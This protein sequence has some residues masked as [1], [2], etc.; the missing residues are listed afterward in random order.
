MSISR[1]KLPNASND[2]SNADGEA[3]MAGDVQS[4]ALVVL[5]LGRDWGA[6]PTRRRQDVGV[7]SETREEDGNEINV[8]H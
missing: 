7:A 5:C 8:Q 2:K 3:E 1:R 4:W 6:R